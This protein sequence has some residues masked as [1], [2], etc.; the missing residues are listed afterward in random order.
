MLKCDGT[1]TLTPEAARLK[2]KTGHDDGI[3]CNYFR[4]YW[5]FVREINWS[6]VNSTYK[7]QWCGA[8]MF[9]VICT[10]TNGW[11]NNRDASDLRRHRA[12][13]YVIVMAL[14]LWDIASKISSSSNLAKARSSIISI[15]VD[16]WFWS[17]AENTTVIFL[18]LW[19]MSTRLE[20]RK[21]SNGQETFQDIWAH[22]TTLYWCSFTSFYIGICL[23]FRNGVLLM[24]DTHRF[25]IDG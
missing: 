5:T 20:N 2:W 8:L 16:Q 15:I 14:Q 23:G 6:P 4:R 10:W 25:C 22:G 24:R 19:Q 7:G 1:G 18:H 3:K 13:Y 17:I 12:Q 9:S 11:V 21:I